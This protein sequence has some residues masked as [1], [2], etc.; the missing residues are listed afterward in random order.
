MVSQNNYLLYLGTNI[1]S[2]F[3]SIKTQF[4]SK[5]SQSNPVIQSQDKIEKVSKVVKIL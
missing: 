4:N 3:P 5:N 1:D 2:T